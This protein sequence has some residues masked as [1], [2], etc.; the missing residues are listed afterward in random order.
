[1][2]KNLG[3]WDRRARALGAAGM[4]VAAFA[5]PWE[6]WLRIGVGVIRNAGV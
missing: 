4:I 3:S 5:A 6:L 2:Q 1:M